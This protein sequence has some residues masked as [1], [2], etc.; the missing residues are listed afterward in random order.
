MIDELTP[1]LKTYQRRWNELVATRTNAGFFADLQPTAIGWKVRDRA[2]YVA[3]LAE[4]HDQTDQI[5]ETWMNGRW[6]AKLHLRD[7][8]QTG[9]IALIKIMERRPGSDDAIGLDHLDFY[10]AT[11]LAKA[12]EILQAEPD[13]HWSAECNDA[14]DGYEWLSVWFAGTEAKIKSYTVLD[15]VTAELTALNQ[16][17]LEARP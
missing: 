8:R 11:Q 5:V 9:G 7:A 14:V 16:K 12:T 4:L 10:T 6:I 3:T 15:I 13:L 1:A 17:I 2:A